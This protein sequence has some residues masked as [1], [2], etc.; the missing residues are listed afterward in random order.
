MKIDNPGKFKKLYS[1]FLE[2]CA[3][4][5]GPHLTAAPGPARALSPPLQA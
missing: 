2:I 4:A 1:P 5:K 3:A